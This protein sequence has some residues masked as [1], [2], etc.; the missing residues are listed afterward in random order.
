MAFPAYVSVMG[1]KQ[2][3]FHGETVQ[4][5]RKDKWM[6]VQSFRMDLESPHDAATGLPT[7]R[8][9]WK[10]IKVVKEW[11]AASPQFL[12]ACSTNETLS[13]VLFEFMKAN[14]TGEEYVYQAVRLTDAMV[15]GV[16]RFTGQPDVQTS[17]SP[18]SDAMELEKVSLTFRTIE[19]TD[20]DGNMTFADDWL[21]S[22]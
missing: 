15:A 18:W 16:Q 17:T 4:A 2:G 8:R 7:G 21:T 20:K 11:G 14:R 12:I 19:V 3:Q 10:P 5:K 22:T 9:Q 6:V 1:S 13:E